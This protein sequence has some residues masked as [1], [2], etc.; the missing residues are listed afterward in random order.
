[1]RYIAST[2]KYLFR[3]FIFIFVFA[4]VP[5][6]FFAMTLDRQNLVSIADTI[7]ALKADFTFG[8]IF[9]YL[10]PINA[11]RWAYSLVCF[12]V[13]VVCLPM[14]L[15]FI[16]KH[17]R[18]GSRSF[19]G[20]AGRFNHNF[21]TTL[22]VLVILLA[23]Y[24]L[25]AV[26]TAGLIYAETLFLGGIACYVVM[27]AIYLAMVA[28]ISYIASIFLLWLPCLQI[29]GYNFVDALSFCNQLYVQKRGRLFL[30]VFIPMLCGVVLQFAVSGL[31]LADNLHFLGFICSELIYLFLILYYSILMFV[32]YFDTAGEERMDVKK[33]F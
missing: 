30:S 19:K 16:E 13:L 32:A 2:V 29:T 23:V 21:L 26:I 4:L 11:G 31:N 12:I 33:K 17:M 9:S 27:L 15:G 25:W 22:A 28:L 10:S 1:M 6:Y 24:E 20:V 14:L 18:I 5:S 8:Q 7:F 3:N